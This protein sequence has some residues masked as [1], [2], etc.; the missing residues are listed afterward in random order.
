MISRVTGLLRTIVLVV[1]L[2][3]VGS[4][5]ADAFDVANKLPNS[6]FNLISVGLLTAVIMGAF[7]AL[8]EAVSWRGLDNLLVPLVASAQMR[9]YPQLAWPDLAG[10]AAVMALLVAL[11]LTW[12]NRLLHLSAQLGAALTLYLFWSLGG[13]PWLVAPLVLLASYAWLTPRPPAGTKRYSLA[14][15]L[16]IGSAG[17]IWAGLNARAPA[18]WA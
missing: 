10:R 9:I 15:V 14:A 12:K 16:C 3:A 13:W 11:M 8:V 5:A 18:I 6:I 7:A 2:G 17:V 1:V 4:Q